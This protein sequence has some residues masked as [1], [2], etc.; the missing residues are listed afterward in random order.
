[1]NLPKFL[2][3]MNKLEKGAGFNVEIKVYSDMSFNVEEWSIYD[4]EQEII[5]QG[6]DITEELD[7][8]LDEVRKYYTHHYI[9]QP[10]D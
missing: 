5:Y 7:E 3:E 4:D 1:M 9:M 2:A 6:D 10:G 8:A